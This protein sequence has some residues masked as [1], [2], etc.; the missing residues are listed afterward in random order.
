MRRYSVQLVSPSGPKNTAR[1]LLPMPK[2]RK[3]L[4]ARCTLTSDPI[5]PQE[6]VTSADFTFTYVI[7][8]LCPMSATRDSDSLQMLVCSPA[9]AGAEA[10]G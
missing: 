4:R 8:S 10:E 7:V 6:P 3:S 1:S 2:I 9:E 5:S